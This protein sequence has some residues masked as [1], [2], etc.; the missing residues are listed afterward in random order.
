VVVV[1]VL[2]KYALVDIG[3]TFH[4]LLPISELS[5]FHIEKVSDML[6]IGDEIEIK[7]LKIDHEKRKLVLSKKEAIGSEVWEEL[8]NKFKHKEL[9]NGKVMNIVKGGLVVD[10]GIR[11]FVPFSQVENHY[12]KDFSEYIDKELLF[13][14][15]EIDAERNKLVLSHKAI[16]EDKLSDQ[17]NELF[18]N[19]KMGEIVEGTVQRMTDFGVFVDIGGF[20]GL[21]H[22]S[23]LAWERV[24]HPSKIISIGDKIVVKVVKIDKGKKK[25]GLS[26]KQVQEGPWDQVTKKVQIGD[27]LKGRIKRLVSYGAF[28][29]VF[30]G[31]E[32]LV[33]ISQIDSK[34]IGTPEEVLK[35]GQE[36]KAKVLDIDIQKKRI[37]LSIKEV[38]NDKD[39][40]EVEKINYENQGRLNVTL[41][42]VYPELKNYR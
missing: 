9:L 40:K 41:G 10:V 1:K 30:P 7:V 31:V 20:D 21:V 28:V 24:E 36:I 2:P 4:G 25:I 23:E 32:G 39:K 17:S 6:K 37:A 42:D 34:H 29:E 35:K 16:E 26:L 11:G 19:I 38:K 14:I 3:F 15:I 5:Q 22:V 12:V 8:F 13:K 18:S 33:H 27:I